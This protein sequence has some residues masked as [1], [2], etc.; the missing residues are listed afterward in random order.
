[1]QLGEMGDVDEKVE[2]EFQLMVKAFR[3]GKSIIDIEASANSDM[4]QLLQVRKN[5]K[6]VTA[7]RD[8]SSALRANGKH[9]KVV[10]LLLIFCR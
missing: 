3:G 9:L 6:S 10:S 2:Y 7:I 1:M 8:G 5:K 4:K